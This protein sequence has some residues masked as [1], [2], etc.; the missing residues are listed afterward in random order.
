MLMPPYV[1]E[2]SLHLLK[3][4]SS[5]EGSAMEHYY[6]PLCQNKR[7]FFDYCAEHFC[8][9]RLSLSAKDRGTCSHK[10][11]FGSVIFAELRIPSLARSL[12]EDKDT[13]TYL[14]RACVAIKTPLDS[15]EAA[16]CFLHEILAVVGIPACLNLVH[17]MGFYKEGGNSLPAGLVMKRYDCTLHTFLHTGGV[18]LKRHA[19]DRSILS[20]GTQSKKPAT[21]HV[22]DILHL[23][24][25][26]A[27]GLRHIHASGFL[28]ND[29][30]V[31]NIFVACPRPSPCLSHGSDIESQ[32]GHVRSLPEA[33]VG[34]LGRA[35]GIRQ[36]QAIT[37]E[38]GWLAPHTIHETQ[39]TTAS[40]VFSLGT[41]VLSALCG[42]DISIHM[43][44]DTSVEESVEPSA[45][46]Q[47][48]LA[49]YPTVMRLLTM[50]LMRVVHACTHPRPS[51][52][53]S[54]NQAHEMLWHITD[55]MFMSLV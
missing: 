10:G 52:R 35:T 21:W 24:V 20:T 1:C 41:I 40:D 29:L 28:H 43:S 25:G 23:L 26:V 50:R 42:L 30:S 36:G 14:N 39:L 18:I 13:D 6:A 11:S 48:S 19:T 7:P 16:Q 33:V 45:H 49:H 32:K 17:T 22:L 27:N 5:R 34:D 4:L 3:P 31:G 38:A 44:R 12:E 15:P 37:L 8:D 47:A 54:A 9:S 46:I 2:T 53:P 55:E 51:C